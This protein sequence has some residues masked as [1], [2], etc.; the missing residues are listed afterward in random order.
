MSHYFLRF[1]SF[2]LIGCAL[3]TAC[4]NDA[5]DSVKTFS[6][7]SEV[8][9]EGTKPILS[10]TSQES[11]K[12]EQTA[13]FAGGCFWGVEAVFEHVKGV[14]EVTSGF[15]YGKTDNGKKD[16]AYKNRHAEAV[17]I[18]FDSSKVTYQQLL[19]IFF[20][21][22]HDPTEL[23]RQGPDVGTE[24]RS[25]IFYANKEQKQLAESYI[26]EL[27][28]AKTF[29]QP[30]V[31]QIAALDAFNQAGAE[32]QNYMAKHPDDTYIVVND[33]PKLE[34]LQRKFPDLYVSE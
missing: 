7:Q 33:K 22:A 4:S 11:A 16:S 1:L 34:N 13:V 6:A 9:G 2:L 14:S 20:Q 29:A 12:G 31:T 19:K 18:T 24:Y 21:V 30:I 5:K 26:A 8:R 28:E 25:A 23:D 27:T 17:K 32:H 15:S 3:L 10:L